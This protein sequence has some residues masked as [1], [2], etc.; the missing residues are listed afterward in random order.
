MLPPEYPDRIHVAFDDHRLVA[1]AGLLLPVTLAHHLGLGDLVD[2]HVDLGRAPGR[3]NAGDK[4]LTLVGSALAGGDCI[5]DAD[6]DQ[7]LPTVT[8]KARHGLV[9]PVVIEINHGNAAQGDK[10]NDQRVHPIA[11][12]LSSLTTAPGIGL[13]N[14]AMVAISTADELNGLPQTVLVQT[15]QTGGNGSYVRPTD[16]PIP[17]LTTRNDMGIATP[18]AQPCIVPNFGERDGQ[19]PRVHD[20]DDP[21]PTVTSRGAGSLFTPVLIEPVLKQLQDANID[22]RRVVLVDGQPHLLDIRFRM[23]QNPELARAMGFDDEE[24]QYEFVGNVT[25]ITKQIG[26]AVPVHLAAALVKAALSPA[27]IPAVC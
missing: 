21:L 14:P 5:D 17:T 15:S 25:E 22:P 2:R 4:M 3:A 26:N 6:V 12:P 13:T 27:A 10:G 18:T 20:V 23:L 19:E 24:S 7:P 16:Q 9:N 11:D 8:T 1:N